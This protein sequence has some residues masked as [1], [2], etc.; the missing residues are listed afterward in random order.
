MTAPIDRSKWAVLVVVLLASYVVILDTT[1]V[2]V[3]LESIRSDFRVSVAGVQ[4]VV[5]FYLA[6]LA[7]V[8]PLAGSLADRIGMGKIFVVSLLG[9]GAGSLLGM[10]ALNLDMLLA[11]RV[12]QGLGGGMLT[13]LGSA[14]LLSTF[15][16]DQRGR[17]LGVYGG[18][19]GVVPTVGPFLGGLLVD[20][21]GWRWIFAVNLAGRG[22]RGTG[23]PSV[24]SQPSHERAPRRR[25]RCCVDLTEL[26]LAD[27]RDIRACPDR[28]RFGELGCRPACSLRSAPRWLHRS[29]AP[30][31]GRPVA[32]SHA[33]SAQLPA[34]LAGRL[35]QRRRLRRRGDR[36]A[37]LFAGSRH[38]SPLVASLYALPLPILFTLTSPFF[39]RLADR[40]S[41][42]WPLVGGLTLLS[43][44]M[45]GF[46]GITATSP[47]WAIAGM[48]GLRGVAFG[49]AKELMGPI[50]F[51]RVPKDLIARGTSLFSAS[52][53]LTQSLFVV[54]LG[55]LI[56]HRATGDAVSMTGI[57]EAYLATAASA[58]AG[59]VIAVRL[60]ATSATIEE[61]ESPSRPHGGQQLT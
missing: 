12:L 38:L 58:V 61:S 37:V 57:H 55:W 36:V 22:D 52:L 34:R 48:V 50:T 4:G 18:A 25:D 42:K 39:G 6:A 47:L 51:R 53:Q 26:P 31:P 20:V 8:T 10:L 21:L 15:D 14:V 1:I 44:V 9:F 23:R 32:D 60:P 17:A 27:H 56:S 33:A 43:T 46:T 29:G 24:P 54:L 28:F 2:N 45:I 41:P 16:E 5:S 19:L 3:A 30:R 11:A 35:G 40:R 13:P 59:L 7:V 49:A